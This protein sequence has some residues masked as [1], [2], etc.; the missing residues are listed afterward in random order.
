GGGRSR[1]GGGGGEGWGGGGGRG[2]RAGPRAPRPCE[3]RMAAWAIPPQPANRSVYGRPRPADSPPGRGA[4]AWPTGG[5]DESAAAGRP[6]SGWLAGSFE[7]ES[8]TQRFIAPLAFALALGLATAG[9]A[10]AGGG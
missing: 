5:R 3:R 1:G 2:G 10:L 8:M 6:Y 9:A 7:E 4:R